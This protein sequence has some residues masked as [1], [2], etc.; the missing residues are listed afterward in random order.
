MKRVALDA[1]CLP[2]EKKTVPKKCSTDDRSTIS[3]Y[4][5]MHMGIKCMRVWVG[6]DGIIILGFV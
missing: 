1:V 5:N 3:K 2:E 6:M 4:Y